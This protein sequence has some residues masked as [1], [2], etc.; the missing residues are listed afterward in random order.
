MMGMEKIRVLYVDDEDK[1]LQSFYANYR[2][3][4]Y[5]KTAI[6]ADS[7]RSILADDWFHVIIADQ[8][9]PHE[10]GVEFLSKYL[11]LN[12]K[13][14]RILMTAQADIKTVISAINEG[15]IFKYI[16][17]PATSDFVEFAIKEAYQVYEL[18]DRLEKKNKELEKTNGELDKFIYSASHDLRAPLLSIL[19]LSNLG[20]QDTNN[21][22]KYFELIEKSTLKLDAFILN[23]IN[24]YKNAKLEVLPHIFNLKQLAEESFENVLYFEGASS[25]DFKVTC[26]TD[27][28]N[29]TTDKTKLAIIFNNLVTNCIRY[30]DITKDKHFISVDITITDDAA[31][32][33]IAD[34]GIGISADNLEKIYLMFYKVSKHSQGSGIGMYIVR[35]AIEKLHGS[36]K[37]ESEEGVGTKFIIKVPPLILE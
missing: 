22:L 30:K 32:I 19:G 13:P 1:N 16:A 6:S 11:I 15:K 2:R 12:P 29:F 9:M 10:T 26:H 35:D 8:R 4:F 17:K 21:Q 27:A 34:N 20:K 7:A 37:I 14:I 36:I 5:V 25:I 28:E 33:V 31:L 18:Q 24:Y 23:L 3:E